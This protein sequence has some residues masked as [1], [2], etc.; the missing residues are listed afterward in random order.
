V[1]GEA[2]VHVVTLLPERDPDR[3]RALEAS[4][5]AVHASWPVLAV[6]ADGLGLEPAEL[7]RR[8]AIYDAEELCAS[9]KPLALRR[10][11]AEGADVAVYLAPG[12]RLAEPLDPLVRAA[13]DAGVGLVP[14][15][16]VAA[17]PEGALREGAFD[18]RVLA[19]APAG[20]AFLDWWAER[21]AR[22]CLRS[23]EEGLWLDQRWLGA[24]LPFFGV[25]VTRPLA[26]SFPAPGAV[27]AAELPPELR[28][29]YRVALL[30]AEAESAPE[31]PN[32]LVDGPGAFADWSARAAAPP[33]AGRPAPV[34]TLERGVNLVARVGA[35]A[36]VDELAGAVE[37]ALR[38]LGIPT[39]SIGLRLDGGTG[40]LEGLDP[41]LAPY[42]TTLVCLNPV[43]LV[44]F[45]YHVDA[46]FFDRRRSVGLWLAE[47]T[48]APD[49]AAA[50]GFLDEVWLPSEAAA[51][52]LRA[53]TALPVSA[54]PV[55]VAP[56]APSARRDGRLPDRPFVLSVCDLGDVFQPGGLERANPLGLVEAFE[57]AFGE[58]EGP[59]LVVR[60]VDG[61]R[62]RHA[63]ERVRLASRRRDVVV[64]DGPLGGADRRALVARSACYATLYR[65]ADFELGAAEALAAGRPLVATGTETLQA[66]AGEG[67]AYFVPAEPAQL[68]PELETYWSL[69][70][71]QC[72][73]PAEA[74]RLLRRVFERPEEA[75]AVAA[76]GR[77][78]L[79]AASSPARLAAFLEERLAREEAS[80]GG[81]L[82]GLLR[83]GER[84]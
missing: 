74:A 51:R 2:R 23:P 30:Q 77:A 26:V 49:L 28:A 8:R 21:L 44:R 79:A 57:G 42:D 46:E 82:R 70:T 68:P 10:A 37:E 45:A 47:D 39:A 80:G 69:P 7:T 1:S 63:R 6:P 9:L 55:P 3:A 29:S 78:S 16:T 54:F 66:L 81:W 61:E 14:R 58:D 71:W 24:A 15:D 60:L 50:L 38:G 48:P 59:V 34:E 43:D 65:A 53:R 4:V 31:P 56:P 76:R 72:P 13:R 83:R 27:T 33:A 22:H 20:A 35:D 12:A 36:P 52:G 5:R 62:N 40:R 75:E 19:V 67:G 18:A 32:P 84:R 41:R 73:D 64:L 25:A 11:L 17:D